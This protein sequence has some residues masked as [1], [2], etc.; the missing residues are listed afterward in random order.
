MSTDVRVEQVG[1]IT[2]TASEAPVAEEVVTETPE[3]STQEDTS[4]KEEENPNFSAR[5]AAL[6]RQ[7][8]KIRQDR[9]ALK[10]A[11]E[12][13]SSYNTLKSQIKENPMA[14][15]EHL[16][17]DLDTLILHSLGESAPQE[18]EDPVSKL[19][20]EFEEYKNNINKEQEEK[21]AAEEKAKQDAEA[22]AI[23]CHKAAMSQEIEDNKDKYPLISLDED[24]QAL[25]WEVTEAY[26]MENGKVLSP[27]EAADLVE[28]HL[29]EKFQ[30]MM[31]LKTPK[32]EKTEE[33]K[34]ESPKIS[35]K[36]I[37][38]SIPTNIPKATRVEQPK[39]RDDSLSKAAQLLKWTE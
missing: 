39:N 20:R 27:T 34:T 31:A 2:A 18:E 23:E 35:S 15:L 22:A 19:Q 6:S 38:S 24:N 3:E 25:I 16:G 8:A 21:K 11:Q 5:F 29:D 36:T 26:F 13:M 37:S 30:K 12:E 1:P 10:Q 32:V 33:I 7:E 14:A 9:E 28:A 4:T 17:I